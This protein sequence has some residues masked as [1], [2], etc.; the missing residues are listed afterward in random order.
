MS[1]SARR[2]RANLLLLACAAIWGFAF[3]AQVVGGHMLVIEGHD[4]HA[5]GQSEQGVQVIVTAED[6]VSGDLGG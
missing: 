6:H 5:I 2:L 3:V 1:P 4:R